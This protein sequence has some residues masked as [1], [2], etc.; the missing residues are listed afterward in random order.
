MEA[1]DNRRETLL[2]ITSSSSQSHELDELKRC[3][4]WL[5]WVSE[6]SGWT[7]FLSWLAFIVFAI[8]VPCLS[9]FYLACSD[10]DSNHSRPYDAI[11]Q[12]S[13][14]A[15]AALSFACLSQFSRRYGFQRFLF[16][17]RLYE[18]SET[19]QKGYTAELNTSFRMLLILVVPCFL[20][21]SAY[22]IWWYASGSGTRVPYK[23]GN[24]VLLSDTFACII[25]LGSWLYRTV[26]FFLVCVLFRLICFLQIFRLQHF[27][28]QVFK[29]DSD[30]VVSILREHIRIKRHLRVISHR[31]RLFI[32]LTLIL[33]TVSG[34]LSLLMV[35]RPSAQLNLYET[36]ELVVCSV[37][38]IAGLVII[39][40][41]ATKITHKGQALTSLAAKWSV[42]AEVKSFDNAEEAET[43]VVARNHVFDD[44]DVGDEEEEDE[45]DNTDDVMLFNSST[46]DFQKRQALVTYFEN[47][48]AGIT[49]YGFML[50]RTYC[51][52]V[53]FGVEFS[54]L[55]W[56]LGKTIGIS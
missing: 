29:L 36:G 40:N 53:L 45:I 55:L 10:C 49:L 30:D 27:S 56:L 23:V 16:V 52:N 4:W 54:L 26:L 25:E 6:D 8:A 32:T 34:F 2:P 15:V 21:E 41:S 24:T 39:F 13:L 11:V 12:L 7:T 50:D 19:V 51:A 5:K 1:G 31:Y 48:V 20:V 43:P 3:M 42:C 33:I 17:D 14:S 46:M 28:S 18:E 22:K 38:L 44:D 9:H 47:N 35:T 37:S